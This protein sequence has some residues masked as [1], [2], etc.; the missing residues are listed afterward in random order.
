[1]MTTR[2]TFKSWLLLSLFLLL[3]CGVQLTAV[4]GNVMLTPNESRGINTRD[5]KR[6]GQNYLPTL[7]GYTLRLKYSQISQGYF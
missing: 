3:Q 4:A 2:K 1:M 7:P 6:C 5:A